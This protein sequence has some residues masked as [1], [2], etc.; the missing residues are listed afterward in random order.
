L[1]ILNENTQTIANNSRRSSEMIAIYCDFLLRGRQQ[2]LHSTEQL[3][4]RVRYCFI[5][6]VNLSEL[7]SSSKW[8][9]F[10]LFSMTKIFFRYTC[11]FY[12]FLSAFLFF[13]LFSISFS[14]LFSSQPI[15]HTISQIALLHSITD[16]KINDKNMLLS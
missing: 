7:R 2:D 11:L 13:S 10:F 6:Y 16:E 15:N 8:H 4:A 3:D 12:P 14:L 9:P 5:C 1:Q